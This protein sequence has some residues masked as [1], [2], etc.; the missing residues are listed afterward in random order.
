MSEHR[1]SDQKD[2]EERGDC[3]GGGWEGQEGVR[4]GAGRGGREKVGRREEEDT[5]SHRL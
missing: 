3:E 1:P 4:E 5:G 2:R